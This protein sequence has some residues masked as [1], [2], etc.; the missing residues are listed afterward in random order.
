MIL[1]AILNGEITLVFARFSVFSV[2]FFYFG[3]Y[4][5]V[6]MVSVVILDSDW[7]VGLQEPVVA[8]LNGEITLI[9]AR[10]SAGFFYLGI[11][12]LSLWFRR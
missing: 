3:Y 4:V 1:S 12:C 7:S 11:M 8:I 2:G 6:V 9:F 10:F 5:L